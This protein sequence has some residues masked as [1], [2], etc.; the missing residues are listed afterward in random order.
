M[1][2]AGWVWMKFFTVGKVFIPARER[3]DGEP[4]SIP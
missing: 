1:E 4:G 3:S 2:E